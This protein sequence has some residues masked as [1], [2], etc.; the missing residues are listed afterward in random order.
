MHKLT[1]LAVLSASVMGAMGVSAQD[2]AP[3]VGATLTFAYEDEY[4]FRG[5]KL[6]EE[7]LQPAVEITY[8]GFVFG[9]WGS[10]PYDESATFTN[11]VDVY[12]GYSV[13]MDGFS[14]SGGVTYYTYPNLQDDVFD[15]YDSDD[16]DG[17]NT[18]EPYLGVDFDVIGAPS[19]YVYYDL[20]LESFS[21]VAAA[22]HSIETGE[23]MSL[24]VGVEL[25]YVDYW[26]DAVAA[27]LAF[28]DQ[29]SYYYGKVSADVVYA[30]N[31]VASASFGIRAMWASEDTVG[32][33][34]D[35]DALGAGELEGLDFD[36]TLVWFGGSFNIAY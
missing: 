35:F 4:V 10:F 1:A 3:S 33:S 19:L 17:S 24:D 18:I 20:Q 14:L 36:D 13:D 22:S 31:E 16:G 30:F 12:A 21:V 5:Q 9:L 8:G 2:T 27:V 6:G 29:D 32:D 23:N 25:G 34:D 28:D 15:L 26:G 11:E 7:S